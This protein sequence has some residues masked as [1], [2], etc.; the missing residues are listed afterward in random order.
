MNNNLQQWFNL[1][2]PEQVSYIQNLTTFIYAHEEVP[3]YP[4][5]ENVFKAF[6]LT[7]PDEVKVVLLGQ[8]PYHTPGQAQGLAFSLPDNAPTQPSMRNILKELES[9]LGESRHSQDLTSWGEQGVL[10]LNASLTVKEGQPNSMAKDWEQVTRW[11]IEA[12]NNLPQPIVFILWGKNA[13]SFMPMIK[14]KDI[15]HSAHP[16]P[17]SA[18]R[19]FFGS[20]PFSKTNELLEKHNIKGIDWVH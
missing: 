17:F 18:S 5:K 14:H 8:D 2:S 20:K 3:I 10:L 12:I 9:D 19:G 15:I 13:Q 4:L 1:L 11:F 6:E 7:S 16:S